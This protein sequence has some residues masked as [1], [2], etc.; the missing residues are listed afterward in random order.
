[1]DVQAG[2]AAN[3][4]GRSEE[5]ADDAIHPTR[6]P[7]LTAHE[8]DCGAGPRPVVIRAAAIHARSS[9]SRCAPAARPYSG[10]SGRSMRK[11]QMTRACC[12]SCRL[13]FT[14]ASAASLEACPECGQALLSVP[15]ARVALGYRLFEFSEP[16]PELPIAVEAALPVG[17]PW[18]QGPRRR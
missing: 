18:P 1:M 3:N 14:S 11:G 8:I 4:L 6:Q 15:S 9:R 12:P 2:P 7:A 16:L 5:Y 17:S 10:R 13:R